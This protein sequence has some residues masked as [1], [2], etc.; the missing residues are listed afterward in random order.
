MKNW[1]ILGSVAFGVGFGLN[2]PLS[3]D[4]KQATLV[5][6]TSIPAATAGAWIVTQR[7]K[8]S[9]DRAFSSLVKEMQSLETRKQYLTQAIAVTTTE[10]QNTTSQ[11]NAVQA[12]LQELES[13]SQTQQVEK[14]ELEQSILALQRQ[15]IDLETELERDRQQVRSLQTQSTE[16]QQSLLIQQQELD[17]HTQMAAS[18][19]QRLEQAL[20]EVR[21]QHQQVAGE[22]A[23][24]QQALQ[25]LQHQLEALNHQQETSEQ[26]LR[27]LAAQTT[28]YDN[29][30]RDLQAQLRTLNLEKQAAR[31]QLAALQ[32]QSY[33]LEQQRHRLTQDIETLTRQRQELIESIDSYKQVAPP[34]ESVVEPDSPASDETT[35][36]VEPEVTSP[37]P[38]VRRSSRSVES[39]LLSD[40]QQTRWL[41]ETVIEPRWVYRPFLGSVQLPRY[42]KDGVWGSEEILDMV[43]LNLARLG[44]NNL[45][46]QTIRR[47]F[48]SDAKQN[49]LKIFTFAL[50]EYAYYAESESGFWQG[51]CDRLKLPFNG[52]HSNPVKA[53]RELIDDGI[54]LL[55]LRRAEGGYPIVSTLW[56]QS[57]I[58]RSNLHHFAELLRDVSGQQGWAALT[59]AA[60]V[61]L[62]HK[63]RELCETRYAGRT[64]LKR[65]LEDSCRHNADPVSGQLAQGLAHIAI[66]LQAQKLQPTVLLNPY[67]RVDFLTH[68]PEVRFFLRDWE[69][70]TQVL[71]LPPK[72]MRLRRSRGAEDLLICLDVRELLIQLVLPEQTLVNTGWTAGDCFIPERRWQGEIDASGEVAIPEFVQPLQAI[73]DS[74]ETGWSWQLW[75]TTDH[76]L[77]E[78][79]V[80]GFDTEIPCLFFDAVSGD[81]LLPQPHLSNSSEIYCYVPQGTQV[82]FETDIEWAEEGSIPCNIRGWMGQKL[83]LKERTATLTLIQAETTVSL[84]WVAFQFAPVLRGLKVKGQ[85]P[86]FLDPPTLWCPPLP[87][88]IQLQLSLKALT[89]HQGNHAEKDNPSQPIVN[90]VALERSDRWQPI[91]LN[92]FLSQPGTYTLQT[93]WE[94][95]EWSERFGIQT[96]YQVSLAAVESL[97]NVQIIDAA[98]R[99]ADLPIIVDST[100]QFWLTT[101]HLNNLWT[102]EPFTLWLTNGQYNVSQTVQA[103]TSGTYRLELSTLYD[104]LP[105]SN[106]YALDYQRFGQELQQLIQCP[107]SRVL[108]G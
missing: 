42:E 29:Q 66:V 84:K 31:T 34:A 103:D 80:P 65:F 57:G 38:Q 46:A 56:F 74:G 71:S 41:W 92:R 48:G 27:N 8:Q 53:F 60:A 98:G 1:L 99:L 63:L 22:L 15:K 104:L 6:L 13:T 87:G 51:L 88:P 106:F 76:C 95:E 67:T 82:K 30:C 73:D 100:E 72:P 20:T 49:W 21:Q 5:G 26:N 91:Q 16:L 89:H 10:E 44:A 59:K 93:Q 47:R 45:D 14:Q 7:E 79:I 40:H 54:K 24:S 11:L 28:E 2:L 33:S 25:T 96:R 86:V 97:D 69:A 55:G 68:L 101:L 19:R 108:P 52:D 37:E 9:L 64:V 17:N 36:P 35:L 4:V 83:R 94:Q 23:Q 39:F 70:I 75:D 50:S 43:G 62:S 3:R 61:D 85:P 78:W 12:Q 77:H 107:K 81:R 90:T 32:S 102:L 58:P 105:P 18:E